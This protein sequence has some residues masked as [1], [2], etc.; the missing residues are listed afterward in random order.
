VVGAW[1]LL[2]VVM[3][4]SPF[5]TSNEISLGVRRAYGATAEGLSIHVVY[6]IEGQTSS[7]IVS[8]RILSS[9]ASVEVNHVMQPICM[10]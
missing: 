7:F 5:V 2:L 10:I 6:A 9:W 1:T 4:W 3:Q 8:N